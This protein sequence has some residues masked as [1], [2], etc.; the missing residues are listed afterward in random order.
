MRTHLSPHFALD[1]MIPAHM[2]ESDVPSDVLANLELLVSEIME[3]LRV[4]IDVPVKIHDAWR[5]AEH[6]AKV[7]GV[8]HSDH[9]SG[10]ACDFHADGGGPRTWEQA[11]IFAF[12]WI[13][14]QMVSRFGQLILEDHRK[15]YGNPS[16]LW[17]H[18]A[19]PT[20]RHPGS[21][22]DVNR[23]LI[24]SSPKDYALYDYRQ[25]PVE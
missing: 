8:A 14:T 17:V 11:T 16:K 18:V 10:A 4:G 12:G 22:D 2:S 25:V 6:N 7:G 9:L 24:S 15:H 21:V 19:I 5:P 13:R 3:P 23:V 1:E 20:K